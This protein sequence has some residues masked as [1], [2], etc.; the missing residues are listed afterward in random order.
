M[1][2]TALTIGPIIKS[3]MLARRTKELWAASYFFSFLMEKVIAEVKKIDEEA[4]ILPYYK[5]TKPTEI[6]SAG[7]FPDRLI[8]QSENGMFDELQSAVENAINTVAEKFK[9]SDIDNLKKFL[10]THIIEF[11]YKK[12]DNKDDDN[13]IFQANDFLA[14][15]ELQA[16]YE[17]KDKD[18]FL[19]MLQKIAQVPIYKEIFRNENFPSIIEIATKGLKFEDNFFA[20]NIKKEDSEIWDKI[21]AIGKNEE[22]YIKEIKDK[23]LQKSEFEKCNIYGKLKQSHKYIAIVQADGDNIS[24]IIKQIANNKSKTNQEINKAINKFSEALS[25]F[26]IKAAEKIEAYGGQN[27]YAGGDDLLFFAPV[28]TKNSNVFQLIEDIDKIFKTE[29]VDKEEYKNSNASMSYGVSITYYKYPMHEALETARN[30][31]F[32]KAKQDKKNAIAFKIMKHSGQSFETIISKPF[33]ME[34]KNMLNNV[35]GL[36]INSVIY[37]IEKHKILLKSIIDKKEQLHN[38]FENFYNEQ[39]HKKD[40][41]KKMLEQVEKLLFETCKKTNNFNKT[42]NQVYAQLR[43]VKFLNTKHNE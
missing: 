21:V 24:E 27:I 1:K 4:I 2:Y 13:I 38:F 31:L 3:L 25:N 20:K 19:K 32:N 28:T 10:N 41:I 34:F 22:K 9:I 14:T 26:T 18:V 5:I 16:N 12:R 40:E 29:I 23:D 7:I 36:E 39:I 11:E 17:A 6:K 43:T 37:N 42:L 30:L 15:C 8:L 33:S 35:A